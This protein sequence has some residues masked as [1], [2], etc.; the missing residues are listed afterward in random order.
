MLVGLAFG[1]LSC[2]KATTAPS[3]F[4]VAA[5]TVVNAIPNSVNIIPV[6]N[7]SE[8]IMYFNGTYTASIGYGGFSEYSPPGGHDTVYVVQDNADTLN[9]GPKAT[10]QM[11]FGTLPLKKGGAYSLFLCGADT[12]SPDYLLTTDTLPYYSPSDSVTGIRFVNLSTGSNAISIN[13][14]G[15]PNG[16]DVTNLAYKGITSFKQ[17]SNNSTT[18]DYLFVIRDGATGDSLTQFDFSIAGSYNNGY[19]LLDPNTGKL[20][21]FKNVTI[22]LIGQPGLTA[23]VPQSAVLIDDY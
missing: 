6:I 20:L 12:T 21:T 4:G 14:E 7:T 11:F 2:Q 1:G 15:S 22:A 19:G 10:G 8:P 5:F 23:V 9:I 3:V 17:Y 16:S 18:L 13:Q